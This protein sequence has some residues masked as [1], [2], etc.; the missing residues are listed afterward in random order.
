[1]KADKKYIATALLVAT[2]SV[3]SPA[4]S[5]SLAQTLPVPSSLHV[6]QAELLSQITAVAE[7]SGDVGAAAR[8]LQTLLKTHAAYL[9]EVL[10]PPL[11]L[12]PSLA[13][14]D[15]W[16]DVGWAVPLLERAKAEHAE[17]ARAHQ[18]I[19]DQTVV[20]FSAALQ[21]GDE[22]TAALA[23]TLAAWMQAE[24]EVTEPA[25]LLI[26]KYLRLLFASRS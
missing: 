14:D 22:K 2:F 1:M 8:P 23:Q 17:H 12:L 15:E 6:Q 16:P 3:A 4:R 18:E 7:Q 13:A 19:T 11:T 9:D 25:T 20:L 10:L 5:S 21:A 24:T 26:D